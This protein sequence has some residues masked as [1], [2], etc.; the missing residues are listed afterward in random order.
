MI[1]GIP[2]LVPTEDVFDVSTRVGEIPTLDGQ[3]HVPIESPEGAREVAG[4]AARMMMEANRL[5]QSIA[6]MR[7]REIT[8]PRDVVALSVQ[9][10]LLHAQLVQLV[11]ELYQNRL[12]QLNDLP[13]WMRNNGIGFDYVTFLMPPD[14][15]EPDRTTVV[16]NAAGFNEMLNAHRG[17]FQLGPISEPR[18]LR[19]AGEILE[20]LARIVAD[21][22]NIRPTSDGR[23]STMSALPL[24][25]WVIVAAA[26]AGAAYG[27]YHLMTDPAGV[28]RFA[29][30]TLRMLGVTN[31]CVEEA[32]ALP[33]LAQSRT[34]VASCVREAAVSAINQ[35]A[36]AALRTLAKPAVIFA[37][38]MGVILLRKGSQATGSPS[39]SARSVAPS[40]PSAPSRYRTE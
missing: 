20:G 4:Y 33:D 29:A 5:D 30:R 31:Q 35:G 21:K 12:M 28:V 14:P 37:L 22:E 27:A 26:T 25:V 3:R 8:P 38:L 9:A 40:A 39:S 32:L 23:V 17:M 7:A 18:Q 24:A 36:S 11:G 13:S 2:T 6:S 15:R 34:A 16:R 19:V 10:S 1:R